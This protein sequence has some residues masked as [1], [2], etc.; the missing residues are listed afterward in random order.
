[1]TCT[2]IDWF[3]AWPIDALRS[4]SKKYLAQVKD[5]GS[6]HIRD[7]IERFMPFAFESTCKQSLLCC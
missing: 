3:H 2:T 5:L 1:V 4:V 6:P 7:V